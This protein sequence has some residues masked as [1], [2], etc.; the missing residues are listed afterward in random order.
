MQA[1]DKNQ[2]KPG[3]R[4]VGA[5]IDQ[6]GANGEHIILLPGEAESVNWED[7]K[8]WAATIGGEL[9]NRIESTLLFARMK[10]E[11][12]A[13]WYWTC[14]QYGSGSAWMQYFGSGYQGYDDRGYSCRARAVRRFVLPE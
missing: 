11:F 3:E 5:I 2:L 8:E 13:D 7:A 4:Y 1:F 10:D 6:D 14:E 9:P 12:K